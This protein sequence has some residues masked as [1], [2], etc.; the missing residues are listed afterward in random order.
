MLDLLDARIQNW[1]R[2]YRNRL[3]KR[4][5][6]SLE[7]LYRPPRGAE[8]EWETEPAKAAPLP[9]VDVQDAERL[10]DAWLCVPNHKLKLF[11][12][13]HYCRRRSWWYVRRRCSLVGDLNENRMMADAAMALSLQ[14]IAQNRHKP[15]A[16]AR[17]RIVIAIQFDAL[18]LCAPA[19]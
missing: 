4:A 8:I 17:K 10:E 1:A 15:V 18:A 19:A 2:H 14:E 13:L 11:L 6:A 9:S 16:Q 12:R 7:G 3:I 5:T